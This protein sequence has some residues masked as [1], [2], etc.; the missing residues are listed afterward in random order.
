VDVAQPFSTSDLS[1]DL[2]H[3]AV[4]R[5][6]IEGRWRCTLILSEV[7]LVRE[8]LASALESGLI[9]N[10]VVDIGSLAEAASQIDINEPDLVLVDATLRDGLEAVRWLHQRIP[11]S[12]V[13]AF[14]V[15]EA[16]QDTSAW[17]EAGISSFIGRPDTLKETIELIT[18]QMD[19]DRASDVRLMAE[20]NLGS[21]DELNSSTRLNRGEIAILTAREE[22]VAQLLIAG[23][24]NKEIARFLNISVPTVK[25]HV[26]NLLGKLGVPRRGKLAL[27]YERLANVVGRTAGPGD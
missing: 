19:G 26:H 1:H 8:L 18:T 10:S 3:V 21:V 22:Q 17:T 9:R 15:D 13:I 11:R 24:S 20:I 23:E 27:R 7:R 12:R 14:N 2:E 25:S 16:T 5:Q 6:R 4:E